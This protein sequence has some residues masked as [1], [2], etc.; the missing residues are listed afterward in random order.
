MCNPTDPASCRS[1]YTCMLISQYMGSGS[2]NPAS[3]CAPM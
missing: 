2:A 3:V 1:G